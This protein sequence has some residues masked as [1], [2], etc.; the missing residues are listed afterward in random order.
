MTAVSKFVVTGVPDGGGAA[1]PGY[2]DG[3][4]AEVETVPANIASRVAAADATAAP[5]AR[6]AAEVG[7]AAVGRVA[8]A[9]G[10]AGLTVHAAHAR[11]A[12][13]RREGPRRAH[14]EARAAV[15]R[16]AAGADLAAIAGELP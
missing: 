9:V 5:A 1:A 10:V 6:G 8:V 15:V 2:D 3:F 16:V 11:R 14:A 7:L 12:R 4:Q 13:R